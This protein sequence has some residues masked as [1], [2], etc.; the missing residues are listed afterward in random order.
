MPLGPLL[1]DDRRLFV[2]G[3]ALF[4]GVGFEDVGAEAL[5][6]LIG[7]GQE[8]VPHIA[9]RIDDQRGDTLQETFLEQHDAEAGLARPGHADDDAVGRE[10][11]GVVH[12]QV[13]GAL[14]IGWVDLVAEKQASLGDV[15]HRDSFRGTGA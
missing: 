9:L 11:R 7:E 6:L 15:G 4:V 3:A 10:V 8:Q 12:D 5:G 2:E 13:V 1:R 14:V